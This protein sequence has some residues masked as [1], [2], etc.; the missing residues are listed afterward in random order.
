MK[1][2]LK[3]ASSKKRIIATKV[4]TEKKIFV[5]NVEYVLFDTGRPIFRTQQEIFGVLQ[6]FSDSSKE[7]CSLENDTFATT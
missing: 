3:I 2:R 4:T 1:R 5:I 7:Y 6:K